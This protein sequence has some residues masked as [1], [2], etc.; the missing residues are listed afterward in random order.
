MTLGDVQDINA[1]LIE[2][3]RSRDADEAPCGSPEPCKEWSLCCRKLPDG[4]VIHLVPMLF[5]VRL[6]I[7]TPIDNEIGCYTDGWCYARGEVGL[8]ILAALT[9]D[10]IGDPEGPWIKQVSTGRQGPGSKVPR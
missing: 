10:G 2:E 1:G 9:W 7:A 4:R 8:A 6:T 5:N 3:A